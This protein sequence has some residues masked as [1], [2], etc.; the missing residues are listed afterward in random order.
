M[1]QRTGQTVRIQPCPCG[2]KTPVNGLCTACYDKRR[3]ILDRARKRRARGGAEAGGTQ[4]SSIEV[5]R[6]L[7]ILDTIQADQIALEDRA[8]R[9]SQPLTPETESLLTHL[10]NLRHHLRPALTTSDEE[11]A[12]IDRP[13]GSPL[14]GTRR[15]A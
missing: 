13:G 14:I 1:P 15:H 11:Q 8:R 5:A 7:T 12:E 9:T 6:L 3:R 2:P 4:L 10:A